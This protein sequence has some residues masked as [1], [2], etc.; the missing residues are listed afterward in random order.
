MRRSQS[1]RASRLVRCSTS[2]CV[3]PKACFVRSPCARIA[4]A[5]PDH[6]TLSRRGDGMMILPKHID[7]LEPLHLLVDSTGHKIYGEGESLDQEYGI[8]SRQK[9]RKSLLGPAPPRPYSAQSAD[10]GANRV[11]C[12]QPDDGARHACLHPDPLMRRADEVDVTGGIFMH[13]SAM[14]P[15]LFYAGTGPVEQFWKQARPALRV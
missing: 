5:I 3:K 7:R 9:W 8:R 11:R 15:G 10:R 1:K 6:T 13:Q 4:I 14:R 2:R 12:T